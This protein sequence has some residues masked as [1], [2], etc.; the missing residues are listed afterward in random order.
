M[1]LPPPPPP[2]PKRPSFA[3]LLDEVV[4]GVFMIMGGKNKRVGQQKMDLGQLF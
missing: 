2:P 4:L 1:L 3:M